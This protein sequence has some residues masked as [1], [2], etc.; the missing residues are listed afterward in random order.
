MSLKARKAVEKLP[1]YKAAKSIDSTK[2][3]Y[4]FDKVIKLA[5]NENTLGFSPLA[6]EALAGLDS[7]YP[8]GAGINL[9]EKLAAHLGVETEQVI[10]GN[11]SFEL[12]FLVGLAFLEQGEET[13]TAEPSFG[14]YKNVTLIMGGQLVSV[15]LTQDYKVDLDGMAAAVSEKTRIIWLCN[16]NNPTGT[17]FTQSELKTFLEKIPD[18][19]VVVLDEAYY[20]YVVEEGY[21]DSVSLLRKHENIIILRTFSKLE[22]L[23]GFRLGYGIANQELLGYLNK[24]RMPMNVNA[25][26]QLAGIAAIDDQNFKE[27]TLANVKAGRQQYYEVLDKWG[28]PYTISNTNFIWFDI[29]QDSQQIVDAF[30]EHGI[31]IRAGRE[32]GYPTKLR[33][34]IGTKEE[35]EQ[36]IRLLSELLHETV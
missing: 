7:Y 4:G 32:F 36:A 15:P 19:I 14:W 31:L 2:K 13:I 6:R 23:A 29:G 34:S 33:I 35:N 5:G 27:K 24:V 9:R 10:L 26:A 25:A 30:L 20:D 28:F 22:G 11:G 8:D 21:P 17:I 3:E 16:P 18:D 12:L 1:V